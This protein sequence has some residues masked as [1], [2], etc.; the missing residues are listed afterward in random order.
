[1]RA[2]ASHSSDMHCGLTQVG[3]SQAPH[4]L[5]LTPPPQQDRRENTMKKTH[6]LR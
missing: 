4:S 1:M 5:L 2:T 6:G 3:G